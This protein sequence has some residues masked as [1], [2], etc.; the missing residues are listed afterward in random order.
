MP[1][2]RDLSPAEETLVRFVKEAFNGEELA[3]F[4]P[5]FSLLYPSLWMFLT[6]RQIGD[7][8]RSPGRLSMSVDG[9]CWRLSYYDPSA[10]RSTAV[11]APSLADGLKR[12]DQAVTASDTVWTGGKK[13]NASFRKLKDS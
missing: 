2:K 5:E 11:V 3:D 6:W 9:S 10:K 4:D 13:K 12:L 8:E 1:S 7:V